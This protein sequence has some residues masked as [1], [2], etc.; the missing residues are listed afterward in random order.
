M[1]CACAIA[2][3]SGWV[4]KPATVC[5]SAPK[6]AVVTVTTAFSVCGYWRTVSEVTARTPSTRI[7]ALTTIASTGFL[8]KISVKFMAATCERNH[9]GKKYPAPAPASS[10]MEP[11][12]QFDF[13]SYAK[14]Q[15]S[16]W[17]RL[18]RND[19]RVLSS[20]FGRRRIGIAGRPYAVVNLDRRA[21]LQL[22]LPA[23]H[24]LGALRQTLDDRHLIAAR[25]TG[26]HEGLLHHQ[27]IRR[28]LLLVLARTVVNRLA[29]LRARPCLR[30]VVIGFLQ[31]RVNRFAVRVVDHRGLRQRQIALGGAGIH[32]NFREH[33]GRQLT[34]M[35]RNGGLD[36]HVAGVVVHFRIDRTDLAGERVIAER[37]QRQIDLL[38]D[39]YATELTLRHEEVHIQRIQLLHRHD[40]GTGVEIRTGID[41]D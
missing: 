2:C 37:V 16:K 25:A 17:I 14:K 19:A 5:A 27:R 13:R 12:I 38:S 22:Q 39:M 10:A 4:M 23:G 32:G 8:M 18:R 6:Y 29:T 41:G 31:H 21:V 30:L 24:H 33:A 35:V 40:R 9:R 3:S 11:G 34:V 36:L 28:K 15:G 7:S 26:D 1:P 20:I